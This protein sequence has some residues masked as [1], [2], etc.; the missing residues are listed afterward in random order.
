MGERNYGHLEA[1]Q[2]ETKASQINTF[3]FFVLKYHLN[4][5]KNNYYLPRFK[6][7]KPKGYW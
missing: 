7:G 2:F 4:N 5:I 6:E 3:Q 1:A